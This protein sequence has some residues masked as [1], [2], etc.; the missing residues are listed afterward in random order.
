MRKIVGKEKTSL[1]YGGKD[2]PIGRFL[3][4]GTDLPSVTRCF[5][6]GVVFH[7]IYEVLF[8]SSHRLLHT[9]FLYQ[10]IHKLHHEFT[11]PVS[12]AAAYAH[13][14]EHVFSNVLPAV[15]SVALLRPHVASFVFFSI[16]GLYLTLIEHSGFELLGGPDDASYHNLHHEKFK[17]NYG[18]LGFLDKFFG[19]YREH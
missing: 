3:K 17:C 8:H 4:F 2:L 1:N 11:D 14:V 16:Q 10:H 6:D 18:A 15:V 9:K 13:P 7:L 12:I 5:I 19:T